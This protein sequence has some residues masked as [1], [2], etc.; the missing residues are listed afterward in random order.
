[1]RLW[2]EARGPCWEA[3]ISSLF[4]WSPSTPS[5]S[6]GQEV[7]KWASIRSPG[8]ETRDRHRAWAVWGIK[9]QKMG[10]W[11]KTWRTA[12]VRAQRARVKTQIQM[13]FVSQ[14]EAEGQI[15][16][17]AQMHKS[18]RF[19]WSTRIDW[20]W[21]SKFNT[22]YKMIPFLSHP[23]T[24]HPLWKSNHNTVMYDGGVGAA[25]PQ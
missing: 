18:D 20:N 13:L 16:N 25:K 12:R 24:H 23:L 17:S 14:K 1:M 9:S 6:K 21:V 2:L 10:H 4:P 7:W 11:D 3:F 19:F 22:L 15:E 8:T 5:P